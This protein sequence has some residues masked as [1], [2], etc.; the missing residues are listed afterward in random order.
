[1]RL[2]RPLELVRGGITAMRE[3]RRA[4]TS[5]SERVRLLRTILL[6]SAASVAIGYVL[7]QCAS[8]NVLSSLLWI[9]QDCWLDWGTN[10]GRHCFSD[11]SMVVD[12]GMRPNPWTY[13]EFLPPDYQPTRTAYPAAAMMPHLLFGAPAKWLGGPRLGLV[14]YL[15]ALTVAVL[16]PAVWAARGTRGLERLVV[17]VALGVVAI[18]VW[19]VIDRGNSAGFVVPIALMFLVALRRGHWGAV[20]LMVVLAAAVKPQFAVLVVALL[21]ARRWRWSGIA[22]VGVMIANLAPYLLWPRDFPQ[23]IAQ[24]IHGLSHFGSSELGLTDVKNLSFAR[25]LL[26]FPDAVEAATSGG[27]LPEGF[28]AGPR[29]LIG[30]VV[31]ILIV[32]SLLALGRRIPPVMAGIVLLAAAALFPSEAMYYYLVFVL[33]V[34][35]LVIRDP[36][37]RLGE[38]IFDRFAINGDCRRRVGAWVRV[39]TALSIAQV[40]IPGQPVPVPIWGQFGARGVVGSTPIVLTTAPLTPILWIIACAVIIVSYV[41]RP[42]NFQDG[43]SASPLDG[44]PETAVSTSSTASCDTGRRPQLGGRSLL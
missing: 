44:L 37:G 22:I 34:A 16:S 11:Y 4:V 27:K 18:P 25:A 14:G 7:I 41:R 6:V 33:P 21:A 2:I 29:L 8:A 42:A 1:M 38:G 10:I 9:P 43:D 19:A 28:L 32:V 5:R 30:Y 36:D 13:Q 17:F 3:R 39:A 40:A 35:A 31:L 20:T 12:A 26:L 23:T 15:L 24:T